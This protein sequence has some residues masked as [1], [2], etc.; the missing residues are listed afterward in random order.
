[1]G[2]LCTEFKPLS[3]VCSLHRTPDMQPSCSSSSK[4][5]RAMKL[6]SAV[7]RCAPRRSTNWGRRPCRR[8][9]IPS[10]PSAQTWQ[11]C[12]PHRF[13][14]SLLDSLCRP[15]VSTQNNC[16]KANHLPTLSCPWAN[17]TGYQAGR[18][19]PRSLQGLRQ[20]SRWQWQEGSS[21]DPW[22]LS[23]FRHSSTSRACGASPG[24]TTSSLSLN[25]YVFNVSFFT[26]ILDFMHFYP[27]RATWKVCNSRMTLN[28]NSRQL[29]CTVVGLATWMH[30]FIFYF[31]GHKTIMYLECNKWDFLGQFSHEEKLW[32]TFFLK[33]SSVRAVVVVRL[34]VTQML[35]FRPLESM[36]P[37]REFVSQNSAGVLT[38]HSSVVM[39][40]DWSEFIATLICWPPPQGHFKW[41]PHSLTITLLSCW[42]SISL[43]F[44]WCP[45]DLYR[46]WVWPLA[47]WD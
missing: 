32:I 27:F 9:T 6:V 16:P 43:Y 33:I 1:M 41:P 2:L 14:H 45:R 34:S 28:P 39:E 25:Q 17:G 8:S 24:S 18:R 12:P 38:S 29:L 19:A 26:F 10:S 11:P 40:P 13:Y 5:L 46:S 7:A 47:S 22:A 36:K 3:S 20:V 4:H 37:C 21:V 23:P 35:R 42:I 44:V 30:F 31:E 15:P